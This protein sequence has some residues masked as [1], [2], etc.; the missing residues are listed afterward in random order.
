MRILY[1]ECT[2][3]GSGLLLLLQATIGAGGL[4]CRV[5]NGIGCT[6]TAQSTENATL[7]KQPTKAR[8]T[9]VCF[10]DTLDLLV[11]LGSIPYGTYT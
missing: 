5:R 1:V 10:R 11:R 7:N 4:N 2:I 9:A 8:S 6:P 3:L